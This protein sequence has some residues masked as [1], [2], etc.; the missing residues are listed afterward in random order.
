ME[1]RR[2]VRSWHLYDWANSAFMTV[3]STVMLQTYFLSLSADANRVE[4]FGGRWV[5]SGISLW[6]Y[7]AALSML[8][9]V[10]VSPVLR[11]IADLSRGKK[12]F[13]GFCVFVG[14][15]FTAALSLVTAGNWLLC[16]ALYVAANFLW[17]AGN[18]F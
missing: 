8:L 13:L 4:L 3:V 5:T 10:I 16:S 18:I 12:R 2:A 15:L 14:A 17:S 9:G 6:T 7:T 11:A 1:D